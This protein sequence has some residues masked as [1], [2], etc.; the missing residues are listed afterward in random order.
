MIPNPLG[1][2]SHPVVCSPRAQVLHLLNAHHMPE[3]GCLTFARSNSSVFS[4]LINMALKSQEGDNVQILFLF[5]DMQPFDFHAIIHWP[6]LSLP[7]SLPPFLLSFFLP[8]SFSPK[9]VF[10]IAETQ[11]LTLTI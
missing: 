10:F 2:R 3:P 7:P 8:F 9:S 4:A 11:Y 6:I 1:F 5:L